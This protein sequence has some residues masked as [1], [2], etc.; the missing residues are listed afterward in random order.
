MPHVLTRT[1]AVLG[2]GIVAVL[3]A[4]LVITL[5]ACGGNAVPAAE[6]PALI[7]PEGTTVRLGD[8]VPDGVIA[9]YWE[10]MPPAERER[11]GIASLEALRDHQLTGPAVAP[12][13]TTSS[14]AE[15]S[16]AVRIITDPHEIER[17]L[18]DARS[19]NPL[20]DMRRQGT[21][22]IINARAPALHI[23]TGTTVRTG[24]VFHDDLIVDTWESFSPAARESMRQRTGWESIDD[25]RDVRVTGP[26]LLP[27]VARVIPI[28]P[29]DADA[30]GNRNIVSSEVVVELPA[31]D[32]ASP[33]PPPSPENTEPKAGEGWVSV[34]VETVDPC[35]I[36]PNAI[37]RIVYPA[38]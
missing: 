2:G 27:A 13:F 34:P 4:A 1:R 24:D 19:A 28:E 31:N 22:A 7:V 26:N 16:E 10:S 25:F 9:Y 20:D 11:L 33:P 29:P 8:V 15:N 38:D 32:D 6:A 12:Y 14:P 17:R 23:P 36:P 5:A 3:L 18:A 37:T 30:C 35:E 21:E